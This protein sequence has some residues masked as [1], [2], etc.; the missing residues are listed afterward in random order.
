MS[1]NQQKK[2]PDYLVRSFQMAITIGLGV[3]GGYRID[4]LTGIKFPIFTVILSL[5]SV[6]LAIYILVRDSK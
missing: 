4:K 2:Q 1:S 6:A 3:Y 5:L